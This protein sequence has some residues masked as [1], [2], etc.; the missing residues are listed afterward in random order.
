MNQIRQL[1]VAYVLNVD[2]LK[3]IFDDRVHHIQKDL[4]EA[5]ETI[6]EDKHHLANLK[7]RCQ[8]LHTLLKTKKQQLEKEYPYEN[9]EGDPPFNAFG[10]FL[11]SNRNRETGELTEERDILEDEISE[12][13]DDDNVIKLFEEKTAKYTELSTTLQKLERFT[14]RNQ[15]K[16][17]RTARR[18]KE[19][20]AVI[21]DQKLNARFKKYMQ[22]MNCDGEVSLATHERYE[23][24]GIQIK[25]RFREESTLSIL[26]A[27][28]NSGGERSVSTIMFL[29]ALQS[30]HKSCFRAVD[31]INQGMD[32][33]NER[34]VVSRIVA[35]CWGKDK[36]QFFLIT[37]KL[38]PCLNQFSQ[39]HVT[40]L[41]VFNAP[42][43]YMRQKQFDF[44]DS[45]V[46]GLKRKRE[47]GGFAEPVDKKKTKKEG[48]RKGDGG[49]D[50]D[51]N[52]EQDENMP[53][54]AAELNA[55]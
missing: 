49:D 27:T 46:P 23:E 29:L 7:V 2:V 50:S 25:V 38:L 31:E 4:G 20:L 34:L 8:E 13:E 9:R 15:S 12:L 17:H 42:G 55:G 28:S 43:V 26:S 22:A 44:Y 54:F 36:P 52:G 37:P 40:T 18:W 6:R 35:N 32:E 19:K 51:D 47:E 30:I 48:K 11:N 24:Y 14:T 5:E 33:R 16:L 3:S 39:P 10:E 1:K 53:N 41:V 45:I 21:C